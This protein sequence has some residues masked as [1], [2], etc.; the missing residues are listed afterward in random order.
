MT[1]D[2]TFQP[3]LRDFQ[4]WGNI[5]HPAINCRAIFKC[6]YETKLPGYF[7][8]SLRDKNT[9]LLADVSMRQNCRSILIT[10]SKIQTLFI[11][12]H[13]LIARNDLFS[14]I[15]RM[16]RKQFLRFFH[17]FRRNAVK[18]LM[19]LTVKGSQR[20]NIQHYYFF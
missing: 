11:F 16:L 5:P 4:K 10:P 3:S 20:N 15:Y 8:M 17:L 14:H 2:S 13:L 1:E 6:L 12:Y 7:Q 9:G 18:Y 19:M